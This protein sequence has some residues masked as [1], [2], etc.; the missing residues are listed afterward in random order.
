MTEPHP[1][2]TV[3]LEVLPKVGSMMEEEKTLPALFACSL[4]CCFSPKVAAWMN[5]KNSIALDESWR[6]PSN[7]QAKLQK[8]QTFQA[9]IVAN[10]SHLDSIKAVSVK[11]GCQRSLVHQRNAWPSE[12]K[13]LELNYEPQGR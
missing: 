11:R 8:Q 2:N 5:E 7:L 4:P 1:V 6:D 9:E 10:R 13:L 12:I 3:S